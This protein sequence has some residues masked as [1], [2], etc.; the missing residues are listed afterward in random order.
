MKNLEYLDPWKNLPD[1]VHVVIAPK[2]Y[3]KTYFEIMK[4]YK[5]KI[6]TIYKYNL[7]REKAHEIRD[8]IC[9]QLIRELG[10]SELANLLEKSEEDLGFWYA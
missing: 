3:G 1:D 2:G 4:K 8:K 10:Y 9:L 7:D 6:R 5:R